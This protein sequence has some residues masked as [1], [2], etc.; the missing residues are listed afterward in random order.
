MKADLLWQDVTQTIRLMKRS[1]PDI[2]EVLLESSHT[3]VVSELQRRVSSPSNNQELGSKWQ[4]LHRAVFREKGLR[5]GA[6]LPNQSTAECKWF[7]LFPKREQEVIIY[8][9]NVNREKLMR[10]ISQ[11]INR[12]RSEIALSNGVQILPAVMPSMEMWIGE[13]EC[14]PGKGLRCMIGRESMMCQGFPFA[15]VEHLLPKIETALVRARPQAVLE[16]LLG[17]MGGNAFPA[18][19]IAA[20]IVAVL[21]NVPWVCSQEKEEAELRSSILSHLL[22]QIGGGA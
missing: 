20:L 4:P 7:Q 18:T 21:L 1:P 22:Q 9:E 16:G 6:E 3:A 5:W 17:D 10:D 13:I 2:K 15:H 8:Q 19:V 12:D 14:W 11:G